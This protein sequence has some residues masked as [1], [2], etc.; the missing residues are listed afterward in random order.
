MKILLLTLFTTAVISVRSQ[1]DSFEACGYYGDNTKYT[2][3]QVCRF[4][5]F[6]SDQEGEE[7]IRSILDQ[8]G[9]QMN[10]LVL[11]CPDINNALAVNMVGDIGLIRYIIYDN[12]FLEQVED[13]T[14]TEWSAVSILAHEIG[15]HLNGHVLDGQGSRPPKEL[16][17]DEFSGFALYKLGATLEEAQAAM[18]N[19]ASD[20]GS[21][22]HP[23]K[24]ERLEAIK[25]G[26]ENAEKLAPKY[27]ELSRNADY[28]SIAKKQFTMAQNISGHSHDACERRI[29]YY[30]R[31]TEFKSDYSLAWRNRAKY[32]NELGRY[33]E[34]LADANRALSTNKNLWNAYVEKG[35]AY[36]GLKRYLNA[37]TI[38]S[39]SIENREEPNSYD[40]Q[41]RGLSYL[42]LG[43]ITEAKS[44]LQKAYQIEP[45][46]S[47]LEILNQ[48][49]N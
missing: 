28:T 10:F 13:K 49:T 33:A 31:A 5:G 38:F 4:Y 15:H 24:T 23:A 21:M 25:R 45:R 16:E 19:Y 3:D 32:L 17:A 14:S 46:E 35:R 42:R 20:K 41:W 8:M 29:F 43:K 18:A 2:K 6:T 30:G 12:E 7:Y 39:I 22:T 27:R 26:W 11:Q 44:D 34:A 47:I 40:Y 1:D 37:I 9:L 36:Y 48:I